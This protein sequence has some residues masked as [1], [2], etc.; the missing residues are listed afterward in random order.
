MRVPEGFNPMTTTDIKQFFT[1]DEWDAIYD[2]L[3]EY[4]QC[5]DEDSVNTAYYK[6]VNLFQET[7]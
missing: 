1:E 3:C 4:R 5:V 7:N 2:A 6:I